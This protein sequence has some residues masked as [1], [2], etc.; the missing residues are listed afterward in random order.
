MTK[1]VVI[2]NGEIYHVGEWDYQKYEDEE[3]N[4]IVGNP[5]PE[6]A[7][8]EEREM[9]Y[10]KEYGWREVGWKPP[11]SDLD[12]LKISQ[13]EQFETILSIIGGM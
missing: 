8:I 12:R 2:L 11:A 3:G 5:L 13:A 1:S 9:E 7:T 10:T 4:E 6:G